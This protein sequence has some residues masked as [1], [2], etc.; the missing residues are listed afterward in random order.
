MLPEVKLDGKNYNEWAYKIEPFPTT[1]NQYDLVIG[2]GIVPTKQRTLK[3]LNWR[4][5]E[6]SA[7]I[8]ICVSN[9]V[10]AKIKH[11]RKGTEIW[12]TL[13]K[14]YHNTTEPCILN[15]MSDLHNLEFS[16]NQGIA[17]HLTTLK[18]MCAELAS[19]GKNQ[20]E[21]EFVYIQ[22]LSLLFEV[23][24]LDKIHTISAIDLTAKLLQEEE[25]LVKETEAFG[26][27]GLV[28]QG[29]P[30]Q[31]QKKFNTPK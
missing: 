5:K 18:D 17:Q 23:L 27:K 29:K 24:I 8:K 12:Q 2:N 14:L 16:N 26:E 10:F 30:T 20:L 31:N 19:L 13:K 7:F 4:N 9:Y 28:D 1:R 11:I 21:K 25:R 3:K 6:A 15:I 22:V